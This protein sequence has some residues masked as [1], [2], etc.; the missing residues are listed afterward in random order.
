MNIFDVGIIL[1]LCMG[2]IVGWKNGVIKELVSFVGIIIVFIISYQLKGIIG[3]VLCKVLPFLKFKGVL[4]GLSSMNIL[5]YQAIAFLI[6]FSLLLGIYALLVSISKF[7][8]KL[9]NFTIIL[10]L[11][12]KILGGIVGVIKTWLVLFAILVVLIVPFHSFPFFN[13][14]SLVNKVLNETPILNK[15][16]EPFTSATEDI[17]SLAK[18]VSKKQITTN[19]ANLR[20]IDAMLKYKIVDKKTIE[21]LRNYRKIDDIKDLDTILKNY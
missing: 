12:S 20:S 16:V 8:Q 9:V 10:L 14:S 3:N 13:N 21:D 1:F 18:L 5:L 6:V 11:P 17:Y 4:E 7:F 2:F 15:A 19:E